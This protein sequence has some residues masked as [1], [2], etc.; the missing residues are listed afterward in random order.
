LHQVCNRAHCEAWAREEGWSRQWQGNPCTEVGAP[1]PAGSA[2]NSASWRL[3]LVGDTSR[4]SPA[5]SVKRRRCN[6]GGQVAFTQSAFVIMVCS[7]VRDALHSLIAGE[8][9]KKK[10][11]KSLIYLGA[12]SEPGTT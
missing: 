7:P 12:L 4:Y 2:S 8:H 5:L 1:A 10:A 11:P 9:G 3:A 6:S